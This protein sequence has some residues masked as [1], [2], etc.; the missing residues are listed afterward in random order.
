MTSCNPS[1]RLVN[2]NNKKITWLWFIREWLGLQG[3]LKIIYFQTPCH[4][5]GHL[6]LLRPGWSKPRSIWFCYIL[7]ISYFGFSLFL[8]R[9][10][11][12]LLFNTNKQASKQKSVTSK[13]L[14]AELEKRLTH[15]WTN[16]SKS[17]L[18]FTG[19]ILKHSWD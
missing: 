10:K 5:Q 14:Q 8:N 13:F 17:P 1:G 15:K 6:L 12:M 2:N 11:L 7:R 16:S 18:Y 3:P 9:A 4:G 19:I